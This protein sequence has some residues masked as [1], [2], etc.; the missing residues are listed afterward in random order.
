MSKMKQ[1]I[2]FDTKQFVISGLNT[3]ITF[4]ELSWLQIFV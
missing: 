2:G 1:V 3:A 4:V